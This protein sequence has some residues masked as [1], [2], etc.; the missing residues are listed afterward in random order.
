MGTIVKKNPFAPQLRMEEHEGKFYFQ[1]P[2]ELLAGCAA[3]LVTAMRSDDMDVIENKWPAWKAR[4]I[5]Q[6]FAKNE[7]CAIS[8]DD[9]VLRASKKCSIAGATDSN[10]K[11][12]SRSKNSMSSTTIPGGEQ[13]LPDL[14]T[15]RGLLAL[16][17]QKV[18]G[19]QRSSF[20]LEA[21][22]I[23]AM[24]GVLCLEVLCLF[25]TP[26]ELGP[27]VMVPGVTFGEDYDGNKVRE[28]VVDGHMTQD[29]RRGTKC[30]ARCNAWR[31]SLTAAP[32]TLAVIL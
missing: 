13:P 29:L 26:A 2:A 12:V 27:M 15:A 9:L 6:K 30:F 28:L 10:G 3:D 18:R 25:A 7:A 17:R 8:P 22:R 16:M 19:L 5:W 21:K 23:A 31:S 32:V 14:V 11:K 4:G 20:P 1:L 24:C